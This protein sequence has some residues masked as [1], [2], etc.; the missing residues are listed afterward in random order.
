MFE[1][2]LSGPFAVLLPIV[3]VAGVGWL[4]YYGWKQAKLR[5]EAMLQLA[6]KHGLRFDPSRDHSIEHRFPQFGCFRQ[7]DR[8][9]GYNTLR[10]TTEI[11]GHSLEITAGDY[12]Y[13]R[14]SGSGKNRSTTTY[15]FSYLIAR[16]PWPHC[17]PLLIREEGLFDKLA[18]AV[19]FDDIDFESA[20]FS[21][22]F[23]VKGNDKRFAYDVLDPRMM[24]FLLA[25]PKLPPL[26]LERGELLVADSVIW[27]PGRFEDTLGFLG[28]FLSR[29]PDHVVRQ[30]NSDLNGNIRE[31][32]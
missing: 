11:A 2:L 30:L 10:G 31:T 8:R 3:I 4:I 14:T 19:G 21:K 23:L 9:H 17:P 22:R 28:H 18:A 29:W 20:E 5:R 6:L 25:C 26:D 15:R 1:N 27:Q 13:T 24:E 7:G 32:A 16:L 12:S